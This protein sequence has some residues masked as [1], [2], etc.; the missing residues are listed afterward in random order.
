MSEMIQ[1]PDGWEVN[2]FK[3]LKIKLIDGD[4]GENYPKEDEFSD[5]GFCI[6]LSAKNV[7]KDGFKFSEIQ[8]INKE[9]DEK[10]RKGKLEKEDIVLTTRGTVGNIAYFDNTINYNHIRINSGMILLR[11]EN[12]SL[13]TE[14]L[15]TFLKSNIFDNQIANTVFGSA[16]PQLTVKEIEKFFIC[17]PKEKKEQEKIAKI[18][19]TLDKAIESTN[20]LIEKEKNIKI[21]LMQELLTNGIDKDGHIRTKATHA[22]KESELGL[23]PE[24]WE[25]DKL[26]E[27]TKLMTDFVANGS[28]ESLA[29]NVTVFET[30]DFAYYVRLVDIRKGLGHEKQTYVDELSFNFLKKSSLIGREILIAN[31]GA[32]VGET[33]LMPILNKPA[34]IAPNMIVVKVNNKIIPEFLFYFLTFYKGISELQNVTEGSGQPKINKTKLK[35]INVLIPSIKEQE[36]II[37]ILTIQDKKIEK[38]GTN[39]SKLKDLKKGL[40]NDLLSGNV[41]VK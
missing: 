31:I 13:E 15:H 38:E 26:N 37:K 40:M 7:T 32:N 21:A 30:P 1:V 39:L 12:K 10:L 41:R 8:F 18:I 29:D 34:T 4:R 14:Y 24:E 3:D 20:R 16:Q 17:F 22:Y 35:T 25:V 23:I 28:F 27:V 9:K 33:F 6:F 5:N 11:N 2:T 36:K 19:S